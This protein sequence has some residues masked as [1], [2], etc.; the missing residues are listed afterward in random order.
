MAGLYIHIP[1]CASRCIYCGFYSTTLTQLQDRYVDAVCREMEARRNWRVEDGG[2]RIENGGL[3]MENTSIKDGGKSISQSSI[4]HSQS[5]TPSLS[6]I[7]LGGG[8]PSQLSASNLH[9]LFRYINKVYGTDF[10][11]AA[12]GSQM[13]ITMEC[14]P[15]DIT[16]V[17]CDTLRTL[18]VNRISMGAQTFSDDRLRFLRRRHTAEE[19]RTAV[20]RLRAIGIGNISIDLMFGFPDETLNEWQSDINECLALDVEH[21]SAY[22]LMYEED[23][24]L[25]RM[26]SEGRIRETDD[27]LSSKMYYTLIDSLTASGF[28]HYEISNFA[29]KQAINPD[30]PVHTLKGYPQSTIHKSSG[31]RQKGI[32]LSPHPSP[33]SPIKN[34]FRSRHNSS[35]WH[36][37]PYIGLGASAHSYDIHSRQWNVSDVKK[38][39]ES[40]ERGEIPYEREILDTDTR[41]NETIMTALRT[42]EGV[43]I[44]YIE[45]AFGPKYKEHLLG[46]A[47]K[48]IAYGNL[49]TEGGRLHL[50]RKGIYISDG[51]TADLFI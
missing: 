39:T 6:T 28:E 30:S 35:Y 22:S 4:L 45:T 17:F 49:I 44:R 10:Q 38:Y 27:E 48:N 43:D 37:I 32:S 25:H 40:I 14:N 19:V 13:E 34:S 42:C 46:N 16:P 36:G 2:L 5:P 1:F 29:K 8:T 20:K 15:D 7:Y 50:S 23:T 47:E 21:I 12:D 3:S 11:Y 33:I 41:Y 9:K 24:P 51:I 26:L 18:P 31:L